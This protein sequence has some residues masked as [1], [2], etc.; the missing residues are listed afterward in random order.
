VYYCHEVVLQLMAKQADNQN[1]LK[2]YV[3]KSNESLLVTIFR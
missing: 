2:L 3:V 1:L